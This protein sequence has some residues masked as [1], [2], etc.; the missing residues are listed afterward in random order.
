MLIHATI[1]TLNHT[2]EKAN[3]ISK[4]IIKN[5][6]II[7]C[8]FHMSSGRSQPASDERVKTRRFRDE[9]DECLSFV[10]LV[11]QGSI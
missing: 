8:C 6:V 3:E 7:L 4:K 9:K 1:L 2:A 11:C 10:N 5:V